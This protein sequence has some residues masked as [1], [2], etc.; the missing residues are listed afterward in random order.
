[1]KDILKYIEDGITITGNL[2]V[3][4]MIFTIPTQHFH[5]N[6]LLELTSSRL[7]EEVE[8]QKLLENIQ[9]KLWKTS[10]LP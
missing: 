7:Q 8:K 1:M 4:Y 3:G 9:S 6:S 10:D 2:N 5:I